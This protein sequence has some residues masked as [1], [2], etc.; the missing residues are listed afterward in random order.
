MIKLVKLS[1]KE[2]A[3]NAFVG[4]TLNF[5]FDGRIFYFGALYSSLVK[6]I[7]KDGSKMTVTTRNSVYEFED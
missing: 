4:K 5:S 3:G 2:S 7:V 6:S 1:N